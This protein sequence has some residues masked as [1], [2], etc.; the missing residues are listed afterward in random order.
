[1]PLVSELRKADGSLSWKPAWSTEFQDS[2]GYTEKPSLEN[3]NGNSKTIIVFYC[4]IS[5][6][7]LRIFLMMFYLVVR[8]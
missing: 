4:Y 3:Q 8:E 2:Q 6:F 5:D 7:S 1:M